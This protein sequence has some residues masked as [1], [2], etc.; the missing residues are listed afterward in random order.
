MVCVGTAAFPF[1][2]EP[3]G[4][5]SE[6]EGL[7][8][9][10]TPYLLLPRFRHLRLAAAR[11]ALPPPPDHHPPPRLCSRPLPCHPGTSSMFTGSGHHQTPNPKM[12]QQHNE[13]APFPP[14]KRIE[15][16]PNI[17]LPLHGQKLKG[18]QWLM[19]HIVF[20][21]FSLISSHCIE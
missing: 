21:T 17:Q 3:R 6:I 13:R 7:R 20:V 1:G 10:P 12:F 15:A 2:L 19:D 4:L 14:K 11:R 5:R 8:S 18:P 16:L 9:T